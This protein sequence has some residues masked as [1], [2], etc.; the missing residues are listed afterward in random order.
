VEI[1]NGINRIN[2]SILISV[3]HGSQV[4]EARRTV[5]QFIESIEFNETESGQVAI[6]VTELAN[7]LVKHSLGGSLIVRGLTFGGSFG[8]E[9]LSLDRG[10]GMKNV[11]E[12]LR[13]GF[14]TA[15]SP[16]TGLGAIQRFSQVFDLHSSPGGTVIVSQF[17]SKSFRQKMA[18]ARPYLEV[19]AVSLPNQGESVCGDDWAWASDSG[20]NMLMVADGLG[21]GP[22]AAL[23]STEA[24]AVL[25]L[26]RSR[27]PIEIMGA[28]HDALKKT[29]GAAAALIELQADHRTVTYV[30]VGNIVSAVVSPTRGIRRMASQ[31]GTV[32]MQA[33]RLQAF[34]FEWSPDSLFIMHSDGMVGHWK[35]DPYPG[36]LNKHPSVIAGLFYRDFK[37]GTDDVTILVAREKRAE[38]F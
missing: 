3:T 23:A 8:V 2:A 29:R 12:C 4:G 28:A 7:N 11:G 10:P 36:I 20:R 18:E 24:T 27:P 15:G 37:R 1:K 5:Q 26:K 30:G 31:N 35:L 9:V 16:G 32:G 17:W 38:G 33:P 19:G 22:H 21:H 13:D 6:I 34:N 14:S 25:E